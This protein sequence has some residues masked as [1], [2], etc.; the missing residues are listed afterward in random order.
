MGGGLTF[1]NVTEYAEFNIWADCE[2]AN[3]VLQQKGLEV[4]MVGLDATHKIHITDQHYSNV[5]GTK[6]KDDLHSLMRFYQNMYH[7]VN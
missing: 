4:V 6:F 3:L 5:S 7:S 2:A 1:G